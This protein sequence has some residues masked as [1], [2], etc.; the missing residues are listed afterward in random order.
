MNMPGFTAEASLYQTSEHFQMV[1]GQEGFAEQTVVPQNVNGCYW[2]R[3][4][5]LFL[6]VCR[7]VC[8]SNGTCQYTGAWVPWVGQC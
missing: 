1:S 3:T 7:K 5:T 4:C 2:R 8:C 6:C